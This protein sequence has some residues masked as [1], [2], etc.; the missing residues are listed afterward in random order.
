MKR[1]DLLR[2]LQN[3]GCEL[4]REG[5]NHSWIFWLR[6][7]VRIW[8]LLWFSRPGSLDGK[9]RNLSNNPETLDSYHT[10]RLNIVLKKVN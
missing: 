1:K 6:R 7:F 4:L 2:H 3:E 10:D 8:G 5:G 9:G